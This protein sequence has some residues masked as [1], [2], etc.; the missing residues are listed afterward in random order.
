MK[1]FQLLA[2]G[3]WVSLLAVSCENSNPPTTESSSRT[4]SNQVEATPISDTQSEKINNET[5]HCD[6]KLWEHVYHASRLR[7]VEEC[8]QITGTIIKLKQ[9]DDGDLHIKVKLD[10]GQEKLINNMNI[11][12]QKGCMVIEPICVKKIIKQKNARPA[13]E[14]YVNNVYIPKKGEHV[15]VTGSYVE[16]IKHGWMEI[17]PVT[18]IEVME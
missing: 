10:K 18:K 8:K 15:R 7:V 3:I 2:L 13:C 5:Y 14:G 1:K 12:R 11:T 17:H 9:E 6:S 4:D 16:D